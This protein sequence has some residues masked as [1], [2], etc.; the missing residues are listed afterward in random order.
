MLC[1]LSSLDSRGNKLVSGKEESDSAY[2]SSRYACELKSILQQLQEKKLPLDEYPSVL[3]MPDEGTN[4]GVTGPSNAGNNAVIG[5]SARKNH[6]SFNRNRSLTQTKSG[7]M[8]RQIIFIAGGACYSELRCAQEVTDKG[9]PET[10]IGSTHFVNP[11]EFVKDL[12][13]L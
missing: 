11:Q 4:L 13:T 7:A 9:G 2:T 3:P 10:I 5:G 8:P 12:V 1:L 6:S